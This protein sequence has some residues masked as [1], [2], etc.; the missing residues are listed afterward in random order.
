MLFINGEKLYKRRRNQNTL[1]PEHAQQLLT[2]TN[3]SATWTGFARVV[4][5]EEIDATTRT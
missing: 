3:C 2:L 4:D 5:L 1:E